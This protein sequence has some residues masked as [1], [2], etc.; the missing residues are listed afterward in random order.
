MY[1]TAPRHFAF[2]VP[3]P[4]WICKTDG[5]AG[6]D[7]DGEHDISPSIP[8]RHFTP[9]VL[10]FLAPKVSISIR[11]GSRFFVKSIANRQLIFPQNRHFLAFPRNPTKPN[12]TLGQLDTTETQASHSSH[13]SLNS[14]HPSILSFYITSTS[15]ELTQN[16]LRTS[17]R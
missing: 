14:I 2:W 6:R 8:L 15:N 11:E 5:Q 7:P 13:Y 3:C 16:S 12:H 1:D 9:A 17:G 10:S 4:S